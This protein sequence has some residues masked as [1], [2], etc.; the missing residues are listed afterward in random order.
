MPSHV[1]VGTVV[2]ALKCVWGA[3]VWF[4]M[5]MSLPYMPLICQ[6]VVRI[7]YSISYI[8]REVAKEKTIE[9]TGQ[10]NDCGSKQCSNS[11]AGV[12]IN[13]AS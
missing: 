8:A 11:N 6:A 12:S 1:E 13:N 4:A 9:T 5:F 7:C 10:S 2:E 3:K